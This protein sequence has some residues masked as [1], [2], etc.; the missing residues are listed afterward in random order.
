MMRESP[1]RNQMKAREMFLECHRPKIVA[2]YQ[3]PSDDLR[4]DDTITELLLGE[5]FI[6]RSLRGHLRRE[7]VVDRVLRIRA[8]TLSALEERLASPSDYVSDWEAHLDY[9][10]LVMDKMLDLEGLPAGILV[11]ENGRSFFGQ[12][13]LYALMH[14][15]FQLSRT[16]R[17]HSRAQWFGQW[18]DEWYARHAATKYRLIDIL[19]QYE[20]SWVESFAARN[21]PVAESLDDTYELMRDVQR[22]RIVAGAAA[23]EAHDAYVAEHPEDR[24][25]VRFLN[26]ALEY[27]EELRLLRSQ[28]VFNFIRGCQGVGRSPYEEFRRVLDERRVRIK[29]EYSGVG[30]CATE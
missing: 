26:V 17:Y 20:P 21:Q 12:Q 4:F 30:V 22:A 6:G 18:T 7:D 1:I 3:L 27:N 16:D 9:E 11:V 2:D 8:E 19:E 29:E 5:E 10:S 13:E 15:G 23:K 24:Y 25:Y 28:S 14:Q